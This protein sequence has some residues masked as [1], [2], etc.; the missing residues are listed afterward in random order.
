MALVYNY[1]SNGCIQLPTSRS[2][3]CK[4]MDGHS[5]TYLQVSPLQVYVWSFNFLPPILLTTASVWTVI[6]FPASRSPYHCK[7]MDGHSISCLPFSPLQEYGRSF[8]FLPPVLTT[9]A[10]VWTVIKFL[11]S[12]SNNHCKC[13]GGH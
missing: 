6:Q 4:C 13:M 5:I 1:K 9:T 3:H 12:R 10:S 2:H 7:C 8:N 11:A